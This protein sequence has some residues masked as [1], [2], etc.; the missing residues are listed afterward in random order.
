MSDEVA[1]VTGATGAL[2]EATATALAR[3]G[4]SVAMASRN[5]SRLN[6]TASHIKSDDPS[7]KVAVLPVDL[8][9]PSSVREMVA[10]FRA[11]FQRLDAL[12]HTAAVFLSHRQLTPEGWELM[13]ATNHLGPFLL[14]RRLLETQPNHKALRVILVTA[15][16][17]T[18]VDFED[19]QG[20]QRFRPLW[21]FGA[22]KMCNL[23]F[24]YSLAR[25][26][27][28]TANSANAFHPGLLKSGLMKEA[29]A[30]MRLLTN[31]ASSQPEKAAASLAS[32]ATSPK[33]TS[34]SGK[35][36]KGEQEIHSNAYSLEPT[37]QERLWDLS[38]RLLG[39]AP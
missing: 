19:P 5:H 31:L 9:S 21:A 11:Q 16:S 2:G 20:E 17:T 3:L 32:L 10:R 36:F 34:V 29:P 14:T 37:N 38:T 28:G 1:I 13:F 22:T 7:A 18:S 15:P 8:S 30:P 33:Y 27:Q 4:W 39:L 23:L 24:T 12:I 6:R 25:R 26:F 35:F